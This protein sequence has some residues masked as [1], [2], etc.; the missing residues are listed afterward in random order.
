MELKE[1]KGR[2]IARLRLKALYKTTIKELYAVKATNLVVENMQHAFNKSS[3]ASKIGLDDVHIKARLARINSEHTALTEVFESNK[4]R[5]ISQ[6]KKDLRYINLAR[7]FFFGTPYHVVESKCRETVLISSI[8]IHLRQ[9]ASEFI[10]DKTVFM[11]VA[12]WLEG[13]G[14]DA[15]GSPTQELA[16]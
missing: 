9:E 3:L 6:I 16:Q 15:N 11:E 5:R 8:I 7:A 13:L 2:R 1:G 14:W 10:C 4:N 12:D